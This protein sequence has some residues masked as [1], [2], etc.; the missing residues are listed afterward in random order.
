VPRDADGDLHLHTKGYIAPVGCTSPDAPPLLRNPGPFPVAQAPSCPGPFRP[1]STAVA[2]SAA[3][4]AAAVGPSI[5]GARWDAEG[6]FYTASRLARC[7]PLR[8]PKRH[9]GATLTSFGQ[10]SDGTDAA[11]TRALAPGGPA[12]VEKA[13]ATTREDQPPHRAVCGGRFFCGSESRKALRVCS[14]VCLYTTKDREAGR[15]AQHVLC[16]RCKWFGETTWC[17][18]GWPRCARSSTRSPVLW[19]ACGRRVTEPFRR[20]RRGAVHRHDH[21]RGVYHTK[22]GGPTGLTCTRG[23]CSTQTASVLRH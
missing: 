18:C 15:G 11:S 10:E 4:F 13:F 17:A 2:T 1:P 12:V 21:E 9:P 5:A 14:P 20:R 6:I 16:E 7:L 19:L 8:L 22:W 3:A 23:C